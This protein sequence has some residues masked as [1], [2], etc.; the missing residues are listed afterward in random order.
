MSESREFRNY[1]MS[2]W[3]LQDNYIT[4]LK[5]GDPLFVF[6]SAA[7]AAY[8]SQAR[9]RGQIQNGQMEL[10]I[11]GTQKLSFDIPMYIYIDGQKVENPNWYNTR[12]GNTL[13]S[14][15]KIKVIFNKWG[16]DIELNKKRIDVIEFFNQANGNVDLY[17]RPIIQNPWGGYSTLVGMTYVIN[18]IIITITPIPANGQNLLYTV[19]SGGTLADADYSLLDDY[20][21][22][23]QQQNPTTID[24]VLALDTQ[25]LII[26]AVYNTEYSLSHEDHWAEELHYMGA[27]YEEDIRNKI[28]CDPKLLS[29]YQDQDSSV[30]E[31]LIVKVQETHEK[32]DL[33]CH[34]ECEGLAFNELGK[35]GY[36]RALSADEFNEEYYEWS[37]KTVKPDNPDPEK[38]YDYETIE[39]KNAAMPINN[40]QYWMTKAKIDP[41]PANPDDINPTQ[42]YYQIKMAHTALV[43][44]NDNQ[45]IYD[46]K[47][48]EEGVPI[49][50]TEDGKPKH[51][52]E[53]REK[54]RL[55]DLKESNLYNITQDLAEKFE[56]FCRYE[57]SYDN[58]YNIIGRTIV[59]YN[60]FLQEG[61]DVTTLM[62][63]N[64]ASKVMREMDSADVSTK[65]F[66]RSVDADDLYT[67]QINIMNC[68]ANKSR[69]DYLL[70]FDY[71][72][73]IGT[74]SE[75]QY[76]AINKFE[77]AMQKLNKE[78]VPLQNARSALSDLKTE[79]DAK[80]TTLTNSVELDQER[81]TENQAIIY[82]IDIQDGD[83][84][85]FITRDWRN[86]EVLSLFKDTSDS[87]Q[88]SYY[89]QF[90]SD[91]KCF[92]IDPASLEIYKAYH[93]TASNEDY[94]ALSFT[95]FSNVGFQNIGTS[96]NSGDIPIPGNNTGW[97]KYKFVYK[98]TQ[99]QNVENKT[100]YTFTLTISDA[101]AG[102]YYIMDGTGTVTIGSQSITYNNGDIIFYNGESWQ[103]LVAGDSD[104]YYFLHKKRRYQKN[105]LIRD[106]VSCESRGTHK[107]QAVFYKS[108]IGYYYTATGSS[109]TAPAVP[110]TATDTTAATEFDTSSL[111]ATGKWCSNITIPE[112]ADTP[113]K[114]FRSWR[115]QKSN[116]D[117]V[118][119]TPVEITKDSAGTS[120]DTFSAQL[121]A[122]QDNFL[123][124]ADKLNL[125]G[126]FV[127]DEYG[128]LDKVISLF[129][130]PKTGSYNS[131]AVRDN[132][133]AVTSA[134]SYSEIVT[135]I[136]TLNSASSTT[137]PSNNQG[138]YVVIKTKYHYANGN[139][140]YS[141][142]LKYH[143]EN[144]V[145]ATPANPTTVVSKIIPIFY[146]KTSN[147]A[148]PPSPNSSHELTVSS[149][150]KVNTWTTFMPN[151]TSNTQTYYV[152]YGVVPYQGNTKYY[153]YNGDINAWTGGTLK[154]TKA[155]STDDPDAIP[156]V[157]YGIFRYKPQ[158]YYEQIIKSWTTKL[159]TDNADLSTYTNRQTVLKNKIT[160]LGT[161]I[162]RKVTLKNTKI[163]AF[164]H[165]MGAA[166]RESY[167]QPE[168]EYQ[169][170]GTPYEER[171]SFPMTR[172]M[173]GTGASI[174]HHLN[175]K[176]TAMTAWDGILFTDE[177]KLYY[178]SGVNQ[179]KVYYPCIDLTQIEN[180]KTE[181]MDFLSKY[182]TWANGDDKTNPYSFYFAPTGNAIDLS[183]VDADN[184]DI[185]YCEHYTIG[186][187]AQLAFVRS[188][189]DIKPVLLLIDASSLSDSIL[190][191]LYNTGR[192]GQLIAT[193]QTDG[194]YI[195]EMDKKTSY[196]IPDTAWLNVTKVDETWTQ[197]DENTM[198]SYE[199][200]YP[201]ILIPSLELKTAE[202]ELV[203]KFK[204]EI[205][206][207][208]EHY[209]VL[210]KAYYDIEISDITQYPHVYY[211]KD[212]ENTTP[213]ELNNIDNFK[214]YYTITIKPD[215]L[216]AK[217]TSLGT[218]AV[219]TFDV[220]FK[221]SNAV[222]DIYLDAK[223]ILKENAY[224]KVSYE[225]DVSKWSPTLLANLYKK[226]AQLVM[227]N[228]T[229]LKLQ[230][231]FGY[232]SNIKL[233]LDHEEK[234]SVEVK[235]YKT[236]FE[237]LFSKI[238]AETEEMHKNSRNIGM[239]GVLASGDSVD[240]SIDSEGFSKTISDQS[241]QEILT[242]FLNKYFDG[243]NVVQETLKDAFREAGEILASASQ[244]LGRVRALT[245][246]N[247]SI[248]AGFRENVAAALTPKVYRGN[249]QPSSYKPGDIWIDDDGNYAVAMSY[250]RDG[251]IFVRTHDGKLTEIS[252]ASMD[253]NADTGT[254][255]ILAETKINL[256]SGKNI[257]IAAGD[258]V[259][260]V[261]NKSVN[262]GGTTINM[263]STHITSSDPLSPYPEATGQGG[264]HLLASNYS[265]D[266]TTLIEDPNA[267][268]STVDV[269]GNGITLASKNG[270]VIK[271][272]AGIDI[273]SSNDTNVS[274]ISI[275]KE[276][277]IYI[278]AGMSSQELATRM[279]TD[280]NFEPPTLKFYSGTFD[281]EDDEHN[282][283]GASAELS[284][285][286][287]LLGMANIG[288]ANATSFE[289]TTNQI[290]L[291]AG[292][293]LDKLPKNAVG[294]LIIDDI[295]NEQTDTNGDPYY[296][297]GVQ[298]KSNY[299]GMA[300]GESENNRSL[301]SIKPEKILI[302]QAIR[303]N[304][305]SLDAPDTP[306]NYD[307]S[308]LWLAKNE[309]YIGG[310]GNFTLN[311]NNIKVQTKYMNT[312]SGIS[313]TASAEEAVE[314]LGFA[315]GNR[316]QAEYHGPVSGET[317][318]QKNAREA[319]NPDV[320]LGFWIDENGAKHLV[321][322]ADQVRLGNSDVAAA[323]T[324]YSDLPIETKV[325]YKLDAHNS[326]YNDGNYKPAAPTG[327]SWNTKTSTPSSSSPFITDNWSETF[328]MPAQGE[329]NGNKYVWSIVHLT[330]KSG[331]QYQYTA[332][333][334]HFEGLASNIT[335]R[336]YKQYKYFNSEQD[337]T[338]SSVVA[339]ILSE[340]DIGWSLSVPSPG[341]TTEYYYGSHECIRGNDITNS[342]NTIWLGENP[343]E[344]T[345][346]LVTA[347]MTVTAN[348]V[349]FDCVEGDWMMIKN[350]TWIKTKAVVKK[351]VANQNLY[352]RVHVIKNDGTAFNKD[353]VHESTLATISQAGL[354]AINISNGS[355]V[356]PSV[357][358]SALT[359]EG[360]YV[361]LGSTGKL[362]LLGNSEVF[363]GTSKSNSAMILNKN[364]ISI[365]TQD[366]S[367][368][369]SSGAKLDIKTGGSIQILA[370]QTSDNTGEI[371]IISN[372]FV[373]DSTA[374]GTNNMFY[375]G[376]STGSNPEKYIR[377]SK[378]NG[379]E[380]CGA[381]TATSFILS[382]NA[383]TQFNTAVANSGVKFGVDGLSVV[384]RR[385]A[386]KDAHNV[387]IE[388]DLNIET[389]PIFD[390]TTTYEA[391][392]KVKISGTGNVW[393]FHTQHTAGAWN[394]NHAD[395][396]Y[397]RTVQLSSSNALV[398]G[399]N[400]GFY[401][402]SGNDRPLTD[403][404]VAITIDS[405]K[406]D[407]SSNSYIHLTNDGIDMKGSRIKI[408]NNDVWARDDIIVMNDK[409]TETAT[410]RKSVETIESYMMTGKVT[411]N[412][413][414]YY[415]GEGH[416]ASG[417][418]AE[419][420][421][422]SEGDWVLIKPYYNATTTYGL[423]AAITSATGG[424]GALR[425]M[426]ENF[427]GNGSSWYTYTIKVTSFKA[428]SQGPNGSIYNVQLSFRFANESIGNATSV[429]VTIPV[430]IGVDE[431]GNPTAK[432]DSEWSTVSTV[433][434]AVTLDNTPINLCGEDTTIY[435]DVSRTYGRN[436]SYLS[437]EL[438]CT[439][440]A[441]TSR[442][443]CTVYYYPKI[444]SNS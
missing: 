148:N 217:S 73:E 110:V 27:I 202:K 265:Y 105:G 424:N 241:N 381:I 234:D 2:V 179:E 264:I 300:T 82:G 380:V 128:N 358:S 194:T 340:S 287:L 115:L 62:Y 252:G 95:P 119:T 347:T 398:L 409:A 281:E 64:S 109:I 349:P 25:G 411:I 42:W 339:S 131:Y 61:K 251:G 356:V 7:P 425:K 318:E 280:P 34:V 142:A 232:I 276:K 352:S 60:N 158:W 29:Y 306:S 245:T 266:G 372:N 199:I 65:M 118:Y 1:E 13:T 6:N 145:A 248:L 83:N 432:E 211:Y 435:F 370:G 400:A 426:D 197:K 421:D 24:Q 47:I 17:N 418:T 319:A 175:R 310:M 327:C 240:V 138:K 38:T 125:N 401:I 212:M 191:N 390:T 345:V 155:T 279:Q 53:T 221:I 250:D 415:R 130:S 135:A 378:T 320:G 297:S 22:S 35:V 120:D 312:S 324:L 329:E 134:D 231:T 366:G 364:G 441:T 350:G 55:V 43:N 3:T 154:K 258:S 80:V 32:D 216:I 74:I 438:I 397:K 442:V 430:K 192:V 90:N 235:N 255:D 316:L 70:N 8:W 353:P 334:P 242:D 165:M 107:I 337:L 89:V 294:E 363:V 239:A 112:N 262:I 104:G 230:N 226:L 315:L 351:T 376:T 307:G 172:A 163:A 127:Y 40:L 37:I 360:D 85:G 186:S 382:G 137:Y 121:A 257:Y 102:W 237:D 156:K 396:W 222:L 249:S 389:L 414:T 375:V 28:E 184:Q 317:I 355:L 362:M 101:T 207:N 302:G 291:A 223:E 91:G 346:R 88:D 295:I 225:V 229:D 296:I 84:D 208:Y 348:H 94:Y 259:D 292:E 132:A 81:I 139:I 338:N 106:D 200:V 332:Q 420:L 343:V 254:I 15:R 41:R 126:K 124:P 114:V 399:A 383:Q 288:K 244:S 201:R 161:K 140:V 344:Y 14:M 146:L 21:D 12:N 289:M 371:K 238:V 79:V 419:E 75:E 111:T 108:A 39:E 189:T 341:Q 359:I 149:E 321:V 301:L 272:G 271:S 190:Q 187:R 284:K 182:R 326:S 268:T 428:E 406:L 439:C 173:T 429:P 440:D 369:I 410:W 188:G 144:G 423:S 205:L 342:N 434:K 176:N 193:A 162:D 313:S 422:P 157:V 403:A 365:G 436:I 308:Y 402:I 153:I 164:E 218:A 427:F 263:A 219:N 392:K 87:T 290:L 152:G 227:I 66:V 431:D 333:G 213:T 123:L 122:R 361:M 159:A 412:N 180:I 46:D 160:K 407:Q 374:T 117:I 11:D 136:E 77:L 253:I 286:H 314:T 33:V 171:L 246:K 59:F 18:N 413:I 48:Y 311:T 49:D 19:P 386:E 379:L 336:T 309:V 20:I 116:N 330:Y 388:T 177:Q 196:N 26:R 357:S 4:T 51:F 50:W 54:C 247:A 52:L 168:D 147:G 86:P 16:N 391:G 243:P 267:A 220:S 58:N 277:G 206:R 331:S 278:G 405:I 97:K 178:T 141:Y 304:N 404:K 30:F 9:A 354:D 169:D 261:G 113:Y 10:D 384:H 133:L 260:I 57:Y 181:H 78:I 103:K 373:V 198:A 76:K 282:I 45:A 129:A 323:E 150:Q 328:T 151:K 233:D 274:V 67:G 203:V 204:D 167:W 92:G 393:R 210:T 183:I 325:L 368:G 228:D 293:N 72:H 170:Y 322:N 174:Y 99:P 417:N 270:I 93:T 69:E 31:F 98:E 5:S 44:N 283:V 433:G 209:Y 437:F 23:I 394:E 215:V 377:Y 236:K 224:P 256:M 444:T 273:K 68:T 299:I 305:I 185:R 100:N 395:L 166:L 385:V 298:I 387:T 275:D 195:L 143:D 303:K 269:E 285:D 214:T 416:A 408:N 56:V 96:E 367:I 36:K 71:L 335:Y 63:P 443:P